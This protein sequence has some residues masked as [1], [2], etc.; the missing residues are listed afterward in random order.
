MWSFYFSHVRLTFRFWVTVKSF[1]CQIL[2][3]GRQFHPCRQ[4][5]VLLYS[6]AECVPHPLLILRVWQCE[7]ASFAPDHVIRVHL[8][9]AWCLPKWETGRWSLLQVEFE[10][11]MI[12][13]FLMTEWLCA[14]EILTKPHTHFED[15]V[16]AMRN[17]QFWIWEVRRGR[18]DL[19]EDVG[20]GRSA[21]D[22]VEGSI[23]SEAAK[24]NSKGVLRNELSS[25]HESF[26][27][28]SE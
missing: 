22:E 6:P 16:C 19:G 4:F 14:D 26:F 8:K 25:L 5:D 3:E 1:G 21:R 9:H 27:P 23:V 10:Q 12:I 20:F 7:M 17:V 13:K 24:R 2:G 11:R 15:K 28:Q 18:E